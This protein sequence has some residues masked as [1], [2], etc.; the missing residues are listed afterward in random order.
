VVKDGEVIIVMSSRGG[1]CL[2]AAGRWPAQAVE[3]KE[4]VKI[5][6]ENQTL[7]TLPSRII[8]HVQEACRHDRTASTEAA[9]FRQIY[10]LEVTDHSDQPPLIR[11]EARTS[12]TARKRKFEEVVNGI[13]QEDNSFANGI[14]TITSAGSRCWLATISIEKSET[15]R[16][17]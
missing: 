8:P 5:E 7:A 17:C 14:R 6:R 4:G 1:R 11:I 9:E 13:M 15:M 16:N 12:C 2:A 10:N 3:A